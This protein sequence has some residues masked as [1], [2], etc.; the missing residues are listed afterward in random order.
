MTDSTSLYLSIGALVL[1]L[2]FFAFS[3]WKAMKPHNALKPRMIPWKPMI[4]VA[5]VVVVALAFNLANQLGFTAQMPLTA[6]PGF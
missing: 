2:A 4:L 6:R 5:G 1:G 3:S